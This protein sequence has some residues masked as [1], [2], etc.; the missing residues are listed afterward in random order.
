M[1]LDYVGP[2]PGGEEGGKRPLKDERLQSHKYPPSSVVGHALVVSAPCRDDHGE[3]YLARLELMG[4]RTPSVLLVDD[5]AVIAEPLKLALAA[6]GFNQVQAVDT[7]DLTLKAV[8]A[9]ARQVNAE[10]V[11]LDLHLGGHQVG[12]PMI[13]PLRDMGARVVL[14]TA[15]KDP[16]LMAAGLRAGAE[17]VIDKAMAF[18]KLV[19]V[20]VDLAG[21]RELMPTEERTALIEAFEQQFAGEDQLRRPFETLTDREG[22]V[23]RRLIDGDSPKQIAQDD[24]V[25][26]KTVRGH[27]ERI[28]EKLGVNSQR[29]ALALARAAQWP[30]GD[31]PGEA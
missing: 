31:A 15:S 4:Q 12:V 19:A 26:V 20:L 7:R 5:H 16:R 29:E 24:G 14:F 11:L 10:I 27:I 6:Y 2:L 28:L 9:T 30:V 13:A 23:L 8:T 1:E 3:N 22:Q 18:D 17:A 25:S 21:G